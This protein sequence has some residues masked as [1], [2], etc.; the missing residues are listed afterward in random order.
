M[1]SSKR[2][3]ILMI[4]KFKIK[5]KS[6]PDKTYIV[7]YDGDKEFACECKGFTYTGNCWHINKIKEELK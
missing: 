4:Q 3:L 1:L 7:E 5:S 6:D 2:G